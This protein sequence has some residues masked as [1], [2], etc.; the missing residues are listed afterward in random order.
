MK[1]AGDHV[2]SSRVKSLP[3]RPPAFNDSPVDKSTI[4]PFSDHSIK[5]SEPLAILS[6]YMAC[7]EGKRVAE[8]G[9]E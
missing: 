2:Y 5:Q 7:V 3:P 8:G 6:G 9:R 1:V 4:F